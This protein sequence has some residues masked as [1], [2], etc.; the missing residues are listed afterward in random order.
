MKKR[1]LTLLALLSAL[2]WI[3]AALCQAAATAAAATEKGEAYILSLSGSRRKM[4]AQ[5]TVGSDP[6]CYTSLRNIY[7]TTINAYVK[8]TEYDLATGGI[9]AYKS[10]SSAA[11]GSGSA[12]ATSG[13][14]REPDNEL[15][16]YVH[17][18]KVKDYRNPATVIDEL[19]YYIDQ[20]D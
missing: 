19:S 4:T 14:S 1:M 5:G 3:T 20:V 2:V 16:K 15:R 7:S 8:V 17:Y 11:L 10:A 18:A 6:K 13:L 9:A 12:V